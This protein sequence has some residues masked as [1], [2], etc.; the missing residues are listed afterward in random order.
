M[1][2]SNR[3][4]YINEFPIIIM[5]VVAIIVIVLVNLYLG[6]K[7]YGTIYK[8]GYMI[9][10]NNMTYNLINNAPTTEK[11]D[12][13]VA[14]VSNGDYIYK[15]TDSYY[16]GMQKKQE[17]EMEYPIYSNDGL[18]IYNINENVKLVNSNFEVLNGYYGFSMNYGIIYN[19]GDTEPAD[20][21]DYIFIDLNNSIFINTQLMTITTLNDESIIPVNSPVYFGLKYVNYYTFDGKT[22]NYHRISDI[23]YDSIIR[24]GNISLTY[25]EF[26]NKLGLL[27]VIDDDNQTDDNQNQEIN[28]DDPNEENT[29]DYVKPVVTV[30]QFKSKVYSLTSN[31]NIYDPFNV[32]DSEPTFE[33]YTSDGKLYFRKKILSSGK[34]ELPG[35]SAN[36]EYKVVG[37]YKYKNKGGL[38]I[39]ATFYE[40]TI[41]TNSM[42][43]L[44]DIIITSQVG[45]RYS[46]R[47]SIKDLSIS[48]Y[49]TEAAGAIKKATVVVRTEG[50]QDENV[51]TIPEISTREF[52][53]GK[54]ISFTTASNLKSNT[55]YDYVIK[56]YDKDGNELK[57]SG[58]VAGTV[59]TSKTVPSVTFK[60]TRDKDNNV[61][62]IKLN[63]INPDDVYIKDYKYVLYNG[64]AEIESEELSYSDGASKELVFDDLYYETSY[65]L[66]I[67]GEYD[68][69]DGNGVAQ[70]NEEYPFSTANLGD[71]LN[72]SWLGNES[73]DST[74]DS[75]NATI[76]IPKHSVLD[77]DDTRLIA[78]LSDAEGND[79]VNSDGTFKY[80]IEYSKEEYS[81]EE[82]YNSYMIHPQFEGLKS[83][84]QY[85]IKLMLQVKQL[86]NFLT[87]TKAFN[88]KVRTKYEDAYVM[89][90]Q[91]RLLGSTLDVLLEISDIDKL[92]LNDKV[93]IEIY[94]GKYNSPEKILNE[95]KKYI[96]REV[97]NIESSKEIS[98]N[99]DDYNSDEYTIIVKSN[100]YGAQNYVKNLNIYNEDITEVIN[101]DRNINTRLEM[102]Q[103]RK[104]SQNS[105]KLNTEINIKY[106]FGNMNDTLYFIDC[107]RDNCLHVGYVNSEDTKDTLESRNIAVINENKIR[108]SI[109]NDIIAEDHKFYILTKK[110]GVIFD[111]VKDSINDENIKDN[112]YIL[113]NIDYSTSYEIYNIDSATDFYNK[114]GSNDTVIKTSGD[115]KHYVVTE[116]LDFKTSNGEYLITTS[117]RFANFK[118]TIDFQG[119]NVDLYYTSASRFN[120]FNDVRGGTF[121]NAVLKYHLNFGTSIPN[122][123][124]FINYNV[125]TIENFI[126]YIN[127]ENQ[128]GSFS[129]GHFLAYIN[130][131]SIKN[132]VVYLQSDLNMYARGSGLVVGYNYSSGFVTGGYVASDPNLLGN[133]KVLVDNGT[134]FGTIVYSNKGKVR[135]VYNLVDVLYEKGVS[136][137]GGIATI[138]YQ[139]NSGSI[140]DGALSVAKATRNQTTPP[141][142]PNIYVDNGTIQNNY[143][144]DT[145]QGISYKQGKNKKIDVVALSNSGVLDVILNKQKRFSIIPGYYPIVKM[146]DFMEGK[147]TL[148]KVPYTLGQ[149]KIDVI[150]SEPDDNQK[151]NTNENSK[152]L[153]HV[154]VSNPNNAKITNIKIENISSEIKTQSWNENTQMTDLE[155]YLY[156]DENKT[157]NPDIAKSEYSIKEIRYLNSIGMEETIK[158]E[159]TEESRTINVD[160]YR[161]IGRNKNGVT[162]SNEEIYIDLINTI[163]ANEN[164]FLDKNIEY[165]DGFILPNQRSYSAIFDGNEKTLNLSNINIERGYFIYNLTGTIK[166]LQIKN[167]YI[168]SKNDR[169]GFIFNTSYATIENVDIS[170][171][172]V[173]VDFSGKYGLYFI[174]CLA[175]RTADNTTLNKISSNSCK[176]TLNYNTLT[177]AN[178]Y[179]IYVGAIAG[180]LYF[181]TLNNSYSYDVEINGHSDLVPY[182][183]NSIGGVVGYV[184]SGKMENCY[185]TGKITVD[186]FSAGGLSGLQNISEI[187]NS[188]SSVRILGDSIYVGG[189]VG[190]PNPREGSDTIKNS[191]YIGTIEKS[192]LY[193]ENNYSQIVPYINSSTISLSNNYSLN[194]ETKYGVAVK[195]YK[196]LE[197][198]ENEVFEQEGTNIENQRYYLPYLKEGES[199]FVEQQVKGKSYISASTS[200]QLYTSLSHFDSECESKIDE[201]LKNDN[202]YTSACRSSVELT[203]KNEGYTITSND[204][205]LEITGNGPYTL[206]PNNIYTTIHDV[207]ISHGNESFDITLNIPFYRKISTLDD[208]KNISSMTNG[209][210]YYENVML[211]ADIKLE[212]NDG[213][214]K[215]DDDYLQKKIINL[216]GN[217]KIIKLSDDAGYIDNDN[218]PGISE[219]IIYKNLGKIKDFTFKNIKSFNGNKSHNFGIIKFNAGEIYKTNFE[220]IKLEGGNYVSSIVTNKGK[221]HDIDLSNINI[222]GGRNL[223]GLISTEMGSTWKLT[224]IY[225]IKAD[226]VNITSNDAVYIGGIVGIT[227]SVISDV[228]ATNVEINATAIRTEADYKSNIGGIV[229]K[230]TA[231]KS[232]IENVTI[233]LGK[234]SNAQIGYIGG[235]TGLY[236][237]SVAMSELEVKNLKITPSQNNGATVLYYVGGLCGYCM[238]LSDATVKDLLIGTE[239]QNNLYYRY[240][241]GISGTMYN[242]IKNSSIYDSKINVGSGSYIGG[243]AGIS[244]ASCTKSIVNNVTLNASGY[245]GGIAGRFSGDSQA[246]NNNMVMNSTISSNGYL[247][248]IV[249]YF[250]N[251]ATA[252]Q[253]L[254][255]KNN[256]AIGIGING[257]TIGGIIGYLYQIPNSNS[258]NI[259]KNLFYC[260]EGTLCTEKAVGKINKN[261][262]SSDSGFGRSAGKTTIEESDLYKYAE[263]KMYSLSSPQNNNYQDYEYVISS[264]EDLEAFIETMS[265]YGDVTT[266]NGVSYFPVF[267]TATKYIT[268]PTDLS[269]QGDE[270][271]ENPK[272]YYTVLPTSNSVTSLGKM[273]SA[274]SLKRYSN[275][276]N[277]RLNIDYN[278]YASG[279][280]TVNIE[281]SDIDENVNFYYKI[282]DFVSEYIPITSRSYTLTYDFKNPI[283]IYVTNG[284]NYKSNTVEPSDL[285]KTV[286]ILNKNIYYLNNGILYT[287]NNALTGNFINL[288]KDDV[289]TSD[290]EIYNIITKQNKSANIDYNI[291]PESV[292]LYSFTYNGQKIETYYS[293]SLVNDVIKDYQIFVNNNNLNIISSSLKNKKDSYIIDYYNGNEIQTILSNNGELYNIKNSIKYP[294]NFVNNSIKEMYSDIGSEDNLV[295]I[296]Y[297]SGQVYAFDYNTGREVYNSVSESSEDLL[298]FI[299]KKLSSNK[300]STIKN[301]T[302]F[303]KYTEIK[304]LKDN[305]IINSVDDALGKITNNNSSLGEKKNYLTAYNPVTQNY[306]IYNTAQVFDESSELESENDKIYKNYELVQF[307]KNYGKKENKNSISGII[308]FGISILAIITTLYILIKRKAKLGE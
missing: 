5:I 120:L 96:Y 63:I 250:D 159:N 122:I 3:T 245:V 164:I 91:K 231:T 197:F 254:Q 170:D 289:L 107:G 212:D 208:W 25:E 99:F 253:S 225:N 26:L 238:T 251:S 155:V 132:F 145:S 213:D 196:G 204:D 84:T 115:D 165:H 129:G 179:E 266:S 112:F 237:S 267:N 168:K 69:E 191:A 4:K 41:K 287:E 271:P 288:Y 27:R 6:F 55:I 118:G 268:V 44:D 277:N 110:S 30:D 244:G 188:Y 43:D 301:I 286:G 88:Q 2:K 136:F 142:G 247:G 67:T 135:D 303:D 7:P 219:S 123:R 17:I 52:S 174:S 56:V 139:N 49:D 278:V 117:G 184:Y 80:S 281:F 249:G 262:V 60:R 180:Y 28:K 46:N 214:I 192:N 15:Q 85:T 127:Q 24:I 246:I 190:L 10:S 220:N 119:H 74:K 166:N 282:G 78:Y 114:S 234:K 232:S 227:N 68:L 22:F 158:Y 171:S 38:S 294:E 66:S 279:V 167:L 90:K 125:G 183:N 13:G 116:D 33:L 235:I 256:L 134:Y 126:V 70:I 157:D 194:N 276:Y 209:K 109:E 48:N 141:S 243:I 160:I 124:G 14:Q 42:E 150:S 83:N 257:N 273:M 264:K 239:E 101:V 280:N 32:I 62:T 193:N 181:S 217:N 138:I 77:R 300:A 65:I 19:D 93:I 308:V 272:R 104:N 29:N 185:S 1:K 144:V 306:D 173:I 274:M 86:D 79:I 307:Y 47:I 18:T 199:S 11:M 189:I 290:G 94:E 148:I 305:I 105:N 258:I 265:V 35:L 169:Q 103:Q 53:K 87:N 146:N 143:Y 131:G 206:K 161:L 16:V 149:T 20:D 248:G 236:G 205:T 108:I 113:N 140:V 172:E 285:R 201:Q 297:N 59:Q 97:K 241:G 151:D 39:V 240:V 152:A 293:Y 211:L 259:N 73:I 95:G 72:D 210:E 61:E 304:V 163:N 21:L 82:K 64:D 154:L 137:S 295:V 98:L 221:V 147:Q 121:K 54:S 175:G 223:G 186:A 100:S 57:A 76:W 229:G 291:L 260:A 275:S 200:D 283:E 242:T 40:G 226:K 218:N 228:N 202:D 51:Y 92:I 261:T 182:S 263:F 222:N 224:D 215:I 37:T 298:G 296:K 270:G 89:V 230:G 269:N 58:N 195:I 31:L 12:V 8:D 111:D 292:P 23:Y 36:T 302:D 153:V 203:F 71:I 130:Y 50:S 178:T 102:Y 81:L 284:F 216:L 252:Y 133:S 128:S 187:S 299:S 34:F 162:K 176:I 207:K 9:L 106:N 156:I 45:D 75:I 177:A 233:T 198:D 255:L